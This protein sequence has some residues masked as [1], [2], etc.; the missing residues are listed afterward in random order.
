MDRYCTKGPL[1][2]SG[3]QCRAIFNYYNM[4]TQVFL[5]SLMFPAQSKE[6]LILLFLKGRNWKIMNGQSIVKKFQIYQVG[7]MMLDFPCLIMNIWGLSFKQKKTLIDLLMKR[8][9]IRIFYMILDI[10]YLLK[11]TTKLS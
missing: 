5:F 3:L 11:Q 4:L 6:I 10:Y 7:L 1:R 8:M 2:M 9:I